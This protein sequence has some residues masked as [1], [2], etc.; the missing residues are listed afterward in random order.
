MTYGYLSFLHWVKGRSSRAQSSTPLIR[1][2]QEEYL[3]ES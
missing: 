3:A 2:W 1:Q